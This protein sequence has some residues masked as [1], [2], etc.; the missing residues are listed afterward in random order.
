MT[1]HLTHLTRIPLCTHICT[2]IIINV[3]S[4][5]PEWKCQQRPPKPTETQS[6][7]NKQLY[8]SAMLRALRNFVFSGKEDTIN[9]KE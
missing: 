9:L 3:Q 8:F 5:V 2:L 7:A 6:H 4:L 1:S